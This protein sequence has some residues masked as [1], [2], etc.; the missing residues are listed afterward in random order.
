MPI[1]SSTFF[2]HLASLAWLHFGSDGASHF[3]PV[4]RRFHR[5]FK[6]GMPRVLKIVVIPH[7]CMTLQG[8][9][10]YEPSFVAYAT[11]VSTRRSSSP[12]SSTALHLKYCFRVL[13]ALCFWAST[14]FFTVRGYFFPLHCD[15]QST[16]S[17]ES[18]Y[19]R[20]SPPAFRGSG[21]KISSTSTIFGL[22]PLLRTSCAKHDCNC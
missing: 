2:I 5:L 8:L 16:D 3:Y 21:T 17:I 1:L 11:F 14:I 9:W 18:F 15:L 12:L 6:T 7:N 20:P 22:P 10:Q 19:L 4:Y 13:S